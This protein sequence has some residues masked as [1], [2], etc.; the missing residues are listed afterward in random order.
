[1]KKIL[2]KIALVSVGALIAGGIFTSCDVY[3][4]KG[5]LSPAI[6]YT[7]DSFTVTHGILSKGPRINPDGST[8]PLK[9]TIAKIADADGNV[10]EAFTQKMDVMSWRIV[11][12]PKFDTTIDLVV[13]KRYTQNVS[14]A[15]TNATDGS[16][17]VAENS[18]DVPVGEYF[19]D[20]TVTN[21]TKKKMT[22]ASAV[23]MNVIASSE[24][25]RY[26]FPASSFSVTRLDPTDT[27]YG[28]PIPADVIADC[29]LTAGTRQGE[30][31]YPLGVD[32]GN[33]LVTRPDMPAFYLG[34]MGALITHVI[35]YDAPSLEVIF[36]D[37]NGY[38]FNQSQ[39]TTSGKPMF[40][41]RAPVPHA[42]QSLWSLEQITLNYNPERTDSSIIY[43]IDPRYPF[44]MPWQLEGTGTP[45]G[46]PSG[47]TSYQMISNEAFVTKTTAKQQ[48]TDITATEAAGGATVL[49]D[50]ARIY[51]SPYNIGIRMPYSMNIPGVMKIIIQ[52]PYTASTQFKGAFSGRA[53]LP[54]V[55]SE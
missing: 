42:N 49:I 50:P 14:M 27:R 31:Y 3:D 38:Y 20:V 40:T 30:T 34:N 2:N 28:Y 39:M 35:N 33:L 24:A 54:I 41:A 6:R 1:M 46:V 36:I 45:S 22:I 13:A 9:I 32:Q 25:D 43:N 21:P 5:F 4:E 16:I 47:G 44:P 10:V 53:T 26:A 7:G 11:G 48:I 8:P 29:G 55:E 37:E 15:F 52:L 12:K 18:F 23:K 17:T 19:V 51:I